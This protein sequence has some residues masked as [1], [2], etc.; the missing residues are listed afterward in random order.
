MSQGDTHFSLTSLEMDKIF[1][2]MYALKIR[3]I[4]GDILWGVK[5]GTLESSSASMHSYYIH[6][7]WNILC[8][9]IKIWN[10]YKGQEKVSVLHDIFFSP[11]KI[12]LLECDNLRIGA[13]R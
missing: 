11:V 10:N 5:H 2:I 3:H 6:V 12:M 8:F 1:F 4:K 9:S 7:N 13:V